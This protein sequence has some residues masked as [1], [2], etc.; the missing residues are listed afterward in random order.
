MKTIKSI[1]LK[2]WLPI[3]VLGLSLTLYLV[4]SLFQWSREKSNLF[5]NTETQ[6]RYDLSVSSRE[7]DQLYSQNSPEEVTEALIYKSVNTNYKAIFILDTSNNTI[8]KTGTRSPANE[9]YFNLSDKD[10]QYIESFKSDGKPKLRQDYDNNLIHAYFSLGTPNAQYL[11][12][13]TYL[14]ILRYSLQTQIAN[15][16]KL[17]ID[18]NII[19]A[20]LYIT[21]IA[22][23]IFFYQYYFERP[24]TRLI[25]SVNKFSQTPKAINPQIT[26]HGEFHKMSEAVREMS[27]HVESLIEQ[28]QMAQSEVD[29]GAQLLNSLFTAIPDLFFILNNELTI[30]E[31]RAGS[32]QHLYAPPEV[33]LNKKMNEVLPEKVGKLFVEKANQCLASGELVTFEYELSIG[34]NT[35]IFEARL[36]KIP[37]TNTLI[38]IAR[39]ITARKRNEDF[40]QRQAFYDALTE[41]PNRYLAMDRLNQAILNSKRNNDQTS[42][43]FIDLDDFKKI[44]D[45][46]GHD[47]G[48]A[49]LVETAN[50][51]RSLLRETDTVARLGGDEFILILEQ[52]H[53]SKSLSTLMS[54]IIANISQPYIHE[55]RELLFS[56]SVGL[57][58]Y[59][60]DGEDS[61]TLLRKADMAMYHSKGHGKNQFTFFTESMNKSMTRR[62]EIENQMSSAL[63]KGEIFLHFQPQFD[64]KNSTLIGAEALLRW[65][66]PILGNIS[67]GEFIPIAEQNGM[68]EEIGRVVIKDSISQIRRFH[69]HLN[70]SLRIAINLSPRQT[71]DN[72]LLDY[73]DEQISIH[74]ISGDR[75]EFEI[76]E[77]VLLSKDSNVSKILNGFQDRNI[78]LSMDDFG[79]GYSSLHYLQEYPFD[80]V[81][82]DRSFIKKMQ[83]SKQS[84]ELVRA[85]IS[86][87]H[88]LKLKVLAEG[89]E[90][91]DQLNQLKIF[92]CDYIQG[93][94]MGPAT[95]ADDFIKKW[96]DVDH[97]SE[98]LDI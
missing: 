79:T 88:H 98:L 53:S 78:A 20:T 61:K 4:T 90:S 25:S 57:A 30:L 19:T 89:V 69:K 95:S 80:M 54:K 24:F 10:R 42:V 82:I 56:V 33:F 2:F 66:N 62:V 70:S 87:A 21:F 18:R 49:I 91:A 7:I 59:P 63:D 23:L 22:L 47:V 64:L 9:K 68:I 60:I 3:S 55:N 93:Y 76:T 51:L 48:D 86:M 31:Y 46:L 74:Q 16:K 27:E 67:P 96:S 65:N 5:A 72:T 13:R 52:T 6:I 45:T 14:L 43:V 1:N 83:T 84:F 8:L 92:G 85:I 71:R 77:G 94:Y 32:E 38:T 12:D 97:I 58:I 26:G 39:D 73:L 81:K 29:R 37:K 75:I 35:E 17:L 28:T 34:K 40:V 36:A 11:N 15:S 41:L 44:N 50:R